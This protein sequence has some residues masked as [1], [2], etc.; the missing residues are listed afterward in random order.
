[1][2]G[3]SA[4]QLLEVW[5]NGAA[6]L[7]I[8]RA[9]TILAPA[10]GG[11]REEVASLSLG[12]RDRLLM[13]L[14]EATFG[15]VL[16]AY[17]E[18][19]HCA[20]RLE[21]PLDSSLLRSSADAPEPLRDLETEGFVLRFRLPATMDM[22]AAAGCGTVAEARRLICQ[23]CILEASR[24]D[25]SVDVRE[26]PDSII[27]AF[28]ANL[29]KCDPLAEILIDLACPACGRGWSIVFDVASFF[30]QEINGAA[31]RLLRQVATLARTYGWREADILAMSSRR[32]QFYLEA[33]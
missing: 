12:A 20:E 10:L 14:R 27:D 28:A 16:S 30:W 13:E 6:Q 15:P 24:G 31:Q 23:S 1:M 8:E 2:R 4:V 19:P 33:N 18:C 3:L 32:R 9:L 29:A 21:L 5:E 7:E 26:L 11:S 22:A 25:T 17:T